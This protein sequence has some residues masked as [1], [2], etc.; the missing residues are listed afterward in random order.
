MKMDAEDEGKDYAIEYK[1]TLFAHAF[2]T[3]NPKLFIEMYPK[4]A[5]KE[6]DEENVE[7]AVPGS[8]EEMQAMMREFG[9]G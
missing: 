2:M 4:D 7:F 6:F 1:N 8:P 5:G 3:D 9:L